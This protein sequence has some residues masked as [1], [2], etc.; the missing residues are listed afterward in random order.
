[1][2]YVSNRM[3]QV[4][5]LIAILSYYGWLQIKDIMVLR[6]HQI[7]QDSIAKSNDSIILRRVSGIDIFG[8][9]AGSLSPGIK[10]DVI[11]LL[12]YE[13]LVGDLEFWRKVSVKLNS[14]SEIKVI[15]YC[16]NSQCVDSIKTSPNPPF[17]VLAYGEADGVQAV[18][19]ADK[20]GDAILKENGKVMTTMVSWRKNGLHPEDI[21]QEVSK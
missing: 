19:N 17:T 6:K 18:V 20:N 11:F 15:G 12:R 5:L 9:P 2:K 3:V 21:A 4:L 8:A 1:M 7:A 16:D 13:S 14:H 10:R